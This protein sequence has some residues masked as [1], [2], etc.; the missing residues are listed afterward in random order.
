MDSDPRFP[1]AENERF[2]W[3]WVTNDGS[4]NF[5]GSKKN[6]TQRTQRTQRTQHTQ[7][8]QDTQHA[9][10]T[11]FL[12]SLH[13]QKRVFWKK[14]AFFCKPSLSISDSFSTSRTTTSTHWKLKQIFKL[15]HV[16]KDLK[17]CLKQKNRGLPG[18]LLRKFSCFWRKRA[19]I[20]LRFFAC[21]KLLTRCTTST[22]Y[23][24]PST[25]RELSISAF[26]RC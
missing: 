6:A 4:Q 1:T 5:S 2:M 26:E 10:H 9:R 23:N 17:K 24:E 20:K 14:N 12:P 16:D 8:T 11:H 3:K 22:S 13:L 25:V 18:S 19:Q 7:H 15:P 21:F